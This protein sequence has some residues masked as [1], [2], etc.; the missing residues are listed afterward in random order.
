MFSYWNVEAR[1][2]YIKKSIFKL[3]CRQEI[4]QWN[5]TERWLEAE[6]YQ[7]KTTKTGVIVKVAIERICNAG[8]IIF[9]IGYTQ[10][11]SHVGVLNFFHIGGL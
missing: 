11:T 6:K 7:V 1:V 5:G 3:K 9:T 10:Y 4:K 8:C 2:T